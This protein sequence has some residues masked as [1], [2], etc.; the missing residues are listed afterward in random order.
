M[1]TVTN[2]H[3]KYRTKQLEF[4]QQALRELSLSAI[5][6]KF[7]VFFEPWVQPMYNFRQTLVEMGMDYAIEVYL[8]GASY[9][10]FGYLG[11]TLP[12]VF[13]RSEKRFKPLL[14]DFFDF[15]IF[16]QYTDRF[17][18]ESIYKACEGFLY[19]WWKEGYEESLKRYR[20]RLNK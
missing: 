19:H 20:L 1:G 6:K 2:F 11:E 7:D 4:E 5:E 16:W 12:I 8:L 10:R 15:W 13:L 9:S 3:D 18:D 14:Q 17:M